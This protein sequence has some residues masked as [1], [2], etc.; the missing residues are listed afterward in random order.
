VTILQSLVHRYD[1]LAAEGAVSVPGFSPS[2]ISF[3]IVLDKQGNVVTIDDERRLE[4]RKYRPRL[5]EAPSAPNDRRGEKI[6][7]GTFWDPT[8]YALGIPRLDTSGVDAMKEKLLRKAIEKH[9]AFKAHHRALL[10]GID[11]EGCLALLRFLEQWTPDALPSLPHAGDIPGLNVAFRLRGSLRYVHDSP[12]AHNVIMAQELGRAGKVG[13]C[14]VTG[15]EAPIARLHPPIKNIG[16]KLAPLVSFNEVA[17]ESYGRTKGANAPVSEA[18]A[19]AYSTALNALLTPSHTNAKGRPVYPNRVTLGETTVAFWAERNEAENLVRAMIGETDDTAVEDDALPVDEDTENT[20]LR[21]VLSKMQDGIPLRDAG[22][23]MDPASRVYILGISPNAA[24][25]SVRFWVEQSL[26]DFSRHVQDHWQDM[27]LD[28]PPVP[29]PPPAWRLLLEVAAQRETKNIPSHLSGEV[30]RAILSGLPYPRALLIQTLMRIRADGDANA[31]R[32]ALAKAVVTR[33]ARRSHADMFRQN[34]DTPAWKDTLV[35]LD[36]DETNVGYRLGRLF[37]LLDYA[38]YLSVGSVNAGVKEKFF[39]SASS[40]PRRIFPSLL[41]MSQNHISDARKDATT[42]DRAN[43]TDLEIKQVM[44][45]LEAHTPFPS[46][47]SLDDQGRFIV[48]FYHQRPGKR[49]SKATPEIP[50]DSEKEA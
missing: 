16:D 25:L 44:D 15:L 45:G 4:G 50:L 9:E 17:F 32:V 37:A 41:R 29:W 22:P 13:I 33:V 19:F 30:M 20:K 2:Q 34:P 35:A 38:Q 26:G 39:A 6:V 8:D 43:H 42:W 48:G 31:M 28:P 21:S 46:T 12:A 49:G 23:D 11:D 1:R 24:R 36:R 40:T 10:L 27:K 47:L 5:V 7:S 14:L 18:A 3:T